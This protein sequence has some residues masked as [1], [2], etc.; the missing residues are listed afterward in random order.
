ML[1]IVFAD[2]QRGI[3][4]APWGLLAFL[5][6]A[7]LLLSFT[8][9]KQLSYNM[10]KE[11]FIGE[12]QNLKLE[13]PRMPAGLRAQLAWPKGLSGVAEISFT[14]QADG[15]GI[16]EVACRGVR[17][18]VWSFEHIWLC[19][20][21]QLKL[22][23]FV[24]RLEF[25][26]E[27]RVVPNIRLVQS[28]EIAT[29]VQSALYGVKENRAIGE[30]AE[31]HQ[32]RDFI[33][34]MDVKSIDWKRSAKRRSLVAREL[35]AERNHHVILALD[36]G[37]LMSEEIGG[38]PKIDHAISSALAVAW[39]AA[40]GGDQVGYY[41]YDLRPHSFIAPTQGRQAFVRLRSWSSEQA[42]SRHETNHTLALSELNGRTPKRSLI[43]VFTDL[44]DTTSAELLVENLTILSKRHLLIFVAIR[45]PEAVTLIETAPED[46]DGV[47]VLVAA[48]QAI[49][50][51][52]L[53][54]ERL[55]RLGITVLDATPE[56]ITSQLISTYLEIKAREMI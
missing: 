34:G 35:R 51:R 15:T 13:I 11:I 29:T 19:W 7:D 2:G 3:A 21:S 47:A 37:Y 12:S 6:A 25:A 45:D 39:A 27:I 17:R 38:L 4:L 23:E 31:F 56:T 36:T 48:N 32:L 10:A 44:V 9:R 46:L 28:G 54:L 49:N 40:I 30:G 55:T 14:Q 5:A 53:V 1:S 52:R 22:F 16:A 18:G 41:A 26:L 50:E 33:Q 24:P 8:R 42:Y 20:T 43:I